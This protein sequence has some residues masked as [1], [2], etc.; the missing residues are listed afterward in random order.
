MA[1]WLF[2]SSSLENIRVGHENLLWGF[3]DR[4]GGPE[5]EEELEVVHKGLQ[6]DKALRLRHNSGGWDWGDTRP[7]NSQGDLLR[8]PDA[9]L[10][11][12]AG[13][14]EGPVPLEGVLFVHD[15]Q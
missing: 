13:G 2:S 6:Q 10:A 5:A 4:G 3:W 11:Q 1:S 7:R 9:R 12:R 15:L 14:E 8:R